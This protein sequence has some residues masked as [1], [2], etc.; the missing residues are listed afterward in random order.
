MLEIRDRLLVGIG[1]R[2]VVNVIRVTDDDTSLDDVFLT[3]VMAPA[4][5]WF[6]LNEVRKFPSFFCVML[7]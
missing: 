5:G 3:L 1:S 2:V 4:N 6:E 7:N